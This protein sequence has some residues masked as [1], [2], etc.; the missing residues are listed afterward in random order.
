MTTPPPSPLLPDLS[1]NALLRPET[2]TV[3]FDVREDPNT[4]LLLGSRQR[5]SRQTHTS[6][7]AVRTRS[8]TLRIISRDFL[9]TIDIRNPAHA[10]VTCED[11]YR[12]IYSALNLGIADSEWGGA[13]ER[14]KQDI[15][16]ANRVRRK[17]VFVG[18]IRR[19]DWLGNKPMFLGLFKDDEFAKKRLMPR[20]EECEETWVAVFG[21]EQ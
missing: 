14:K 10:P 6:L 11:V 18:D 9:W 5:P 2:T 16:M 20:G 21:V 1:L 13:G 4:F 17:S 8:H 12:A 7:P 15:E 3:V 19:V